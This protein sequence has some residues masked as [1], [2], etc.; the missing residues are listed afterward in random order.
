[1]VVCWGIEGR[2]LAVFFLFFFLFSPR[3]SPSAIVTVSRDAQNVC[4]ITILGTFLKFV[5][6]PA[7]V[8]LRVKIKNMAVNSLELVRPLKT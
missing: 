6:L 2:G 3:E 5:R 4:A 1:M 8:F 7:I